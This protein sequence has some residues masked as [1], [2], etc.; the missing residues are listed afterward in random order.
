MSLYHIH[1]AKDAD[2]PEWI[3][4][5]RVHPGRDG[6]TCFGSYLPAVKTP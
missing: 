3:W 4:T 2:V 6:K 1:K 5:P